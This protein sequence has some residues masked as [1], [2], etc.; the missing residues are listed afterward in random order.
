MQYYVVWP[1]GQKF[2][3][4]D[5]D[6]LR[7]W[8]SESRIDAQSIIEDAATG[9]QMQASA[10][11]GYGPSRHIPPPANQPAPFHG[12]YRPDAP[13]PYGPDARAKGNGE[14]TAAYILGALGIVGAVCPLTL[15]GLGPLANLI[16]VIIAIVGKSKSQP[17]AAGAIVL[18]IIAMAVGAVFFVLGI[19]SFLAQ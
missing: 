8:Q 2:G 19:A 12:Y 18:N 17:G 5:V 13:Y 7:K 11:L 14:T 6:T 4:V 15:C 1:N 10:L 9:H 3:P 16:G